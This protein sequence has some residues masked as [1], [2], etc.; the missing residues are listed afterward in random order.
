[1]QVFANNRLPEIDLISKDVNIYA[2][3]TRK[4]KP[5]EIRK[6]LIEDLFNSAFRNVQVIENLSWLANILRIN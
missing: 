2:T 3:G 5:F 1:M 4:T 6:F